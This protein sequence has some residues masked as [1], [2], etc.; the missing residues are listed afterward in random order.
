VLRERTRA[1]KFV[2]R[3]YVPKWAGNGDR[4]RIASLAD[5]RCPDSELQVRRYVARP[6]VSERDRDFAGISVYRRCWLL[7]VPDASKI[8]LG[9]GRRPNLSLF[10]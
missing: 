8:L 3:A 7:D 1:E 5:R 10:P 6:G 4:G 9:L 2:A